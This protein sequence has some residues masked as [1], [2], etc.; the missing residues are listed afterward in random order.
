MKTLPIALA[1]PIHSGSD[2]DVIELEDCHQV[3]ADDFPE[4]DTPC[5]AEE[6]PSGQCVFNSLAIEHD[7]CIYCGKR[8]G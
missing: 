5:D 4:I 1:V 7:R 2:P 6:N 8:T 3:Y